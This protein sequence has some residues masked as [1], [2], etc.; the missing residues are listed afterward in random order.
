MR[1]YVC[2]YVCRYICQCAYRRGRDVHGRATRENRAEGTTRSSKLDFKA[3][4]VTGALPTPCL[5][6]ADG[7]ACQIA[8]VLVGKRGASVGVYEA[9]HES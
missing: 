4:L 2:M 8:V 7:K 5:P 9:S 6:I 3:E 1:M